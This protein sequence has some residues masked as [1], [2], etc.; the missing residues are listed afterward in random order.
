MQGKTDRYPKPVRIFKKHLLTRSIQ[1]AQPLFGIRKSDPLDHMV[2]RMNGHTRSVVLHPKQKLTIFLGC[3]DPYDQLRCLWIARVAHR[4]LDQRLENQLWNQGAYDVRIHCEFN[5]Q[6]VSK[7]LLHDRDIAL[8]QSKFLLQRDFLRM[9]R[10][11][12]AP[13]QI[14][15]L[16]EHGVGTANI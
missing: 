1:T 5:L 7:S 10:L 16:C 14:A 11:Q 13:E 4:I 6:I 2:A 12:C 15:E 3:S 9:S 8:Y